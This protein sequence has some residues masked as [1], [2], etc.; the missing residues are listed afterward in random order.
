MHFHFSGYATALL[1][2]IILR[3]F[4]FHDLSSRRIA[5]WVVVCAVFVPYLLAAGFVLSAALKL[6]FAL[7]LAFT[8]LAFAVLQLSVSAR[9]H[10]RL[11]RTLLRISG[12]LLIP[13]MLLVIVYAC[14]EYTQ[15]SWLLIPQMARLHGPLNG[16]GFVLLGVL[17]WL[18][19]ARHRPLRLQPSEDET[20]R[21]EGQL[22]HAGRMS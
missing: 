6:I 7:V 21:V 8:L 1:A 22:S 4:R 3:A 18:T 5:R 20:R 13:G 12:G 9:C 15:R 11:G 10:S 17:A 16:P 14:G 19:E 2:G